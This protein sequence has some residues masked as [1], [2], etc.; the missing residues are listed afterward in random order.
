MI[1][2]IT[3]FRLMILR[4]SY[5]DLIDREGESHAY[6][7][8]KNK[9][10]G[11]DSYSDRKVRKEFK[12]FVLVQTEATDGGDPNAFL[13][14]IRVFDVN[15]GTEVANSSYD[16]NP[17]GKL[18]A[19]IDVRPDVRR[20]GVASQIYSYIEELTGETVYPE[21]THTELANKFWNQSNR[22]FGPADLT[23]RANVYKR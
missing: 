14:T 21:V 20:M 18:V 8:F 6:D 7:Y 5:Q 22:K 23:G 15:D 11:L 17:D 4:E 3:S 12:N 16:H 2:S 13:G 19:T 1:T 9:I 10:K